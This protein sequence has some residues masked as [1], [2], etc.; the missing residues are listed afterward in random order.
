MS[1]T[2]AVSIASGWLIVAILGIQA[3][4]IHWLRDTIKILTKRVNNL[5]DAQ[6]DPGGGAAPRSRFD[7]KGNLRPGS[8]S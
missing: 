3:I 7:S 2:T 6:L 1:F 5:A 4:Q 8:P